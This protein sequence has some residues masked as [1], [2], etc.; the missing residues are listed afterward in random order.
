M[1]GS[2]KHSLQIHNAFSGAKPQIGQGDLP[3]SD[4]IIVA[5][6]EQERRRLQTVQALGLLEDT[7]IAVFDEATQRVSHALS[8]SICFLGIMDRDRLWLRSP[9]GL[10]SIGSIGNLIST[11][12]IPRHESF[13]NR[14]IKSGQVL[15]IDN[16]QAQSDYQHFA[17]VSRY[18]IRAYLGVPLF[19]SSGCCVGTL[20]LMEQQPRPF[21]PENIA[22][23][24]LIARWCMSEFERDR[25]LQQAA[26]TETNSPSFSHNQDRLS[27]PQLDS[28]TQSHDPIENICL[29]KANLIGQMAHELQTPLTSILG[30]TS[31]LTRE[32][33]GPL[34]DKQKEY[35]NIVHYS[36]QYM[37]SLV[38]EIVELGEFDEQKH[39]VELSSVDIEMFC[40]QALKSLTQVSKRRNQT[41]QLSVE[42]GRRLWL[43]DKSKARQ[44]LYHLIFRVI[45]ASNTGSTIRVHVSRK[46]Q[47]LKILIW[48]S[49]PWL[50]EGL[51]HSELSALNLHSNQP[52]SSPTAT[53]AFP[54]INTFHSSDQAARQTDASTKAQASDVTDRASLEADSDPSAI[55]TRHNLGLLLS[56]S[57]AKLHGGSLTLQGSIESGYRYVVSLPRLQ[58]PQQQLDDTD[59]E[60][61]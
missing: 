8:A 54:A 24:E 47:Q 38:E 39:H 53:S 48:T 44:M 2:L 17:L 40:Q 22:L 50:G 1:D 26:A 45:Q 3:K 32:I 60:D 14:V 59:E 41:L 5:R 15:A 51:P 18:G 13:C 19:S 20:A 33:Y 9:V 52:I 31:V 4:D 25:L 27:N 10:S 12:Q 37:H 35:M 43:L 56:Q 29:L 6:D 21:S 57:L 36:S 16:T 46:P 30:M 23:M 34:T 61:E 42:P 28:S 58:A 11:R 7:H 55:A 49:H